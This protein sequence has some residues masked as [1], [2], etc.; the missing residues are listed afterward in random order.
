MA[1]AKCSDLSQAWVA[2]RDRFPGTDLVLTLGRQGLWCVQAETKESIALGAHEVTAVD[3]TAAGDAFIGYLMAGLLADKALPLALAEASAA[4]ALTVTQ[5]GASAAI[6]LR[7]QVEAMLE[8]TVE[9]AP[10]KLTSVE[11]SRL[12][13]QRSS[14]AWASDNT[15][16]VC[17]PSS[18][19]GF[20]LIPKSS[21]KIALCG[22]TPNARK[23]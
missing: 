3:E 4:G 20:K 19:A 17:I 21:R 10:L 1:L 6:P 14:I 2:L 18:R 9:F 5:P 16:I 23:Q 11:P 15:L 13:C 12:I 8:R 22:G 7:D